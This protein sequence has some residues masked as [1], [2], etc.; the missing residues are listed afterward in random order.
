MAVEARV[1]EVYAELRK[2]Y[3]PEIPFRVRYSL[4]TST[5]L[6]QAR[7]GEGLSKEEMN[8]QLEAALTEFLKTHKTN[9]SSVGGSAA[10]EEIILGGKG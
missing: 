1:Q 10:A 6:Q 7:E 3:G 4:E 9:P 2:K 5:K 8:A